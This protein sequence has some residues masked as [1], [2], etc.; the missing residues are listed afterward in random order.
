MSRPVVDRPT[1]L[2]AVPFACKLGLPPSLLAMPGYNPKCAAMSYPFWVVLIPNVMAAGRS[3]LPTF[4][5]LLPLAD[6]TV[7][8]L[9]EQR[10][11]YTVER[12]LA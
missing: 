9:D 2:V 10:L 11:F 8:L 6:R 5:T 12:T 1:L 3:P 4:D 7:G